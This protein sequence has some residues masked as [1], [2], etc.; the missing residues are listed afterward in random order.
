MMATVVHNGPFISISDAYKAI[1]MWIEASDY[2]INGPA[3]EVYLKPAE[4]AARQIRRL[5]QGF[6]FLL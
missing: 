1:L 2:Q 6:N 4:M 3:R 5:L